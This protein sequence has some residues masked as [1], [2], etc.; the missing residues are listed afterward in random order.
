[1]TLR[2]VR[3]CRLVGSRLGLL[4]IQ[5][6]MA[7]IERR[8]VKLGDLRALEV[9]GYTGERLTKYYAKRVAALEVWEIDESLEKELRRNLPGAIVKIV[10]S[11]AEIERTERTYDLVVI[12]NHIGMFGEGHC[13]HFDLFPSLSRVLSDSPIVVTNICSGDDKVTRAHYPTLFEGPHLAHRRVFYGTSDPTAITLDRLAAHYSALFAAMGFETEWYFMQHKREL[14]RLV[15][16]RLGVNHLVL[17]LRRE[18]D[19]LKA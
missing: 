3:L 1:L 18:P 14:Y 13:E 11:F 4:P 10:D 19:R 17:K 8:G 12:D 6:I 15:P 5:R 2:F 16:R 9:F 7:G